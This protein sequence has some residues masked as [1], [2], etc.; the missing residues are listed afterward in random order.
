MRTYFRKRVTSS[1]RRRARILVCALVLAFSGFHATCCLPMSP[2][3][4]RDRHWVSTWTTA[5]QPTDS[6]F[7]NQT[8]RMIVRITLGGEQVRI[9]ISNLYGTEALSVGEVYIGLQQQGPAIV[10]P[11]TGSLASVG[12]PRPEFRRG[13]TRLAIRL[14]YKFLSSLAW[15]SLSSSRNL[16]GWPRVKASDSRRLTFRPRAIRS[17]GED[18]R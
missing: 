5:M 14:A 4:T 7:N 6:G 15:Q 18:A 12:S 13:L 9:R 3:Q 17:R 16:P 1:V 2:A 8:I 10:Q 11:L